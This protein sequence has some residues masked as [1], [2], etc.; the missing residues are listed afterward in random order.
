MADAN[1]IAANI[2]RVANEQAALAR[3]LAKLDA[4]KVPVNDRARLLVNRELAKKATALSDL[5]QK[6]KAAGGSSR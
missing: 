4:N 3:E 5:H 2:K 6:W 1:E